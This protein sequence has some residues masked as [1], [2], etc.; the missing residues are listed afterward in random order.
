MQRVFD[1]IHFPRFGL[2]DRARGWDDTVPIIAYQPWW[3]IRFAIEARVLAESLQ[4]L[5]PQIEHVGGTAVP[6][7]V[8]RPIIDI[9]LAVQRPR[10]IGV[11]TERLRNFGFLIADSAIPGVERT[12]VRRERG[13]RTHHVL[14][15]AAGGSAWRALLAFRER[16]R[17]DS[18]LAEAYADLKRRLG[19][20]SL[21][22]AQPYREAKAA[23]IDRVRDEDAAP[24][25]A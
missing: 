8:A 18:A 7:L 1:G 11:F 14:L 21:L 16:L 4:S 25:S 5:A 9:A 20:L 19:G 12:L 3:P 6:G 2:N 17:A 22:S 13:V 23:F 10:L 24:P 15:V